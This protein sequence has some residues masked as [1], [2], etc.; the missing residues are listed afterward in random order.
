MP[1]W[2]RERYIELAPAYWASTR[3]RLDAKELASELGRI[4]VP[5]ALADAI[6]QSSSG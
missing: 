5:P 3:R 4:T 1:C 2:P 6:E